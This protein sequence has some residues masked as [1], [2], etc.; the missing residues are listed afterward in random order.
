MERI[1]KIMVIIVK[2]CYNNKKC[3]K[4]TG[5]EDAGSVQDTKILG[6]NCAVGKHNGK[7]FTCSEL[8]T[9]LL[10]LKK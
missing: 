6:G 2:K 1:V 5:H 8:A 4:K 3:I 10:T 7:I 9:Q